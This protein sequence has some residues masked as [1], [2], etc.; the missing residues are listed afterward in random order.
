MAFSDWRVQKISDILGFAQDLGDPVDFILYGGD[1]IGRFVEE[2]V[3]YFSEL[4]EYTKQKKVLAVIG[5]DDFPEVKKILKSKNV[6]DLYE[7][8]FNFRNYAFVGVEA[9]TSGPAIVQHTEKEIEKHLSMQSSQVK[10]KRLVILSHTPPYGILDRGIRFADLDEGSHHIGSTSL[11]DFIEV[12]H[13]ELVVCGHCHSHG[14]LSKKLKETTIV[15]VSSHDSPGSKGNIALIEI[16]GLGEINIEWRDTLERLEQSSLMHLHSVGAVRE[17]M[18][19]EV[20][21]KTIP[22]LAKVKKISEIASKSNFSERFLLK[23][24]LRAKSVVGKKTY[25]IA[26]FELP[27]QNLIFFDIETDIACERVW[28]IGLSR[29]GEFTQLYANNWRQERKILKQFLNFLKE[30][31]NSVLVSFSGTDFDKNVILRALDRLGLDSSFFSSYQHID[32][33]QELRRSFIFPNQSFALKDL[34]TYI[35]YP[36]KHPDLDGFFVALEYHQHV[37]EKKSLNPKV[38]EYNEDDVR[39]IPFMIEQVTKNHHQ[40][41]KQFFSKKHRQKV[42]CRELSEKQKEFREFVQQLKDNGIRGEEYR[43]KI[44]KWAKNHSD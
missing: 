14:G 29:D 26:P 8:P 28:L 23:L 38:L 11:R 9:S 22:D 37:E 31:P 3:N 40:I 30:N 39:A 21:I 34:G 42:H 20:G 17:S 24:Q 18:L 25:Q 16:N 12:K 5:N 43:R 32:L 2:G 27:E 6:H 33:C 44:M 1:D 10:G 41:E 19:R 13:V 35:K 15:N 7:K 36:F 4:S